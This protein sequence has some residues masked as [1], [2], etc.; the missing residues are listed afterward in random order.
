MGGFE[1]KQRSQTSS[2]GRRKLKESTVWSSDPSGEEAARRLEGDGGFGTSRP[3]TYT[4]IFIL[5]G[6]G[7]PWGDLKAGKWTFPVVQWFKTPRFLCRGHVMD[8]WPGN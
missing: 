5:K 8:P 4:E 2:P 6:E 1:K 7:S 3:G